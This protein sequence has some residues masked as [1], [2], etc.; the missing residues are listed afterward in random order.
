MAIRDS[1]GIGSQA[2]TCDRVRRRFH[3]VGRTDRAITAAIA[4]LPIS[5]LDATLLWLTRSA[6]FGALWLLI[7]GVLS[8]R[9]GEQRRAAVRGVASLGCTALLVDAILKP[10]IARRRPAA[11]L[12]PTHRRLDPRPTSSSFPSGHSASAAAFATA[13][14]LESP[15]TALV[16]APLA[17]TVAYSRIH[18][19]VHW[20]SDV[21]VGTA[22]GSGIALATRHWWPAHIPAAAQSRG[23]AGAPALADGK[24]LLVLVNPTAGD[25][26]ADPGADIA[27]LLPAAT[28][29]YTEPGGDPAECLQRAHHNCTPPPLALGIAGGDG[30]L[31]AAATV[32]LRHGLPL[33]VF[34]TGTLN[35]FAR[36]LGVQDPGETAA[37]VTTGDTVGVDIARIEF[38]DDTG[39]KTRH[40]LNTA[41]L[42]TYPDLVRIR[43][44]WRSRWG[45]WPA[46]LAALLLALRRAHP[47][48]I[49]LNGDRQRVWIVFIGNG[50]YRPRRAVPAFRDRLD[51]GLLDIRWLRADRSCSRA[52]A[53]VAVLFGTIGHTRLYGECRP[54]EL[55]IRLPTREPLTTDGEVIGTATRI[56]VVSAGRLSVY[57]PVRGD[58]AFPR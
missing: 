27:A 3:R 55:I 43:R 6:D 49:H 26:A 2:H 7:A 13:V 50:P 24:G 54:R 58:S 40:L 15:R 9:K 41:G 5:S 38:D 47:I 39:P 57:R 12:L 16:L 18:T 17:A 51:A 10:V 45:R 19:G 33:A 14:A 30:S 36:D 31:A 52:R 56:R 25:P 37:A 48:E 53:G 32:A 29:V 44:R 4:R 46:F 34:P 42:G 22:I 20:G 8:T 11:E 35:H 21:L 23:I 28:L 1:T